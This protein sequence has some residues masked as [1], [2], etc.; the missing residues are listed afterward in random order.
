MGF[1]EVITTLK[2]YA[3]MVLLQF[4]YSGMFVISVASIKSGMNH[5]VLVVYRNVI[6]AIVIAPF[7]LYF[8]RKVRPKMTLTTVIKIAALA[9]LEPVLDQNLY[10]MGANLTSA[11]FASALYNMIPAMTFIMAIILRVEK[12][13]I[14]SRR[15]QAKIAGSVVTVIGALLMILYKGPVVEFFWSKGRSYHGASSSQSSNW[16]TGTLF[17]LAS[18]VCWSGFYVL[19]S[20]TLES[21]SAEL[22]LATLI[23]LM[24]AMMSSVVTLAVEGANAKPWSIGWDMRL[25]T[26]VYSGVI[27]SGITYYVQGI[28]MKERGPVFV[29]AF[30][31]I[32]MIITA[33]LGSIILAE[34][35][36]LGSVIGAVII[37]IGLY[38]LIWGKSKD[39]ASQSSDTSASLQLPVAA[40]DSRKLESNS[41]H[42]K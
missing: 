14:K 7:A 5:F 9:L 34:Q 2:P 23:C 30:N 6:A 12:L 1:V 33:I 10:Y 27:C 8:E 36:T 40:T 41:R 39:Q 16:L 22:S 4:G 15:S 29:T 25:A 20:N 21:Y 32:C 28:V 3:F 35:I 26:A 13:T 11:S 19:Q 37:V 17:L 31:P 24:G 18:C 42:S 38:A